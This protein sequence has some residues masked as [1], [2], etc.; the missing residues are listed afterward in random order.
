MHKLK[1]IS[2]LFI[3]LNLFCGL[4]AVER[5]PVQDSA[6]FQMLPGVQGDLSS[7]RNKNKVIRLIFV[8]HG[9]TFSNVEKSVAGRTTDTDLTEKGIKQAKMVAEQLKGVKFEKIFVSPTLRTQKTALYSSQ[10]D[11]HPFVEEPLLLE[12]HFGPY[13]GVSEE[14]WKPARIKE[15]SAIAALPTFE[16]KFAFKIDPG[17][18][19]FGEVQERIDLFIK[20][21]ANSQA[22]GNYLVVTHAAVTKALF[23]AKSA[24]HGYD[25]EYYSFSSDNCSVIVVEVASSG[26]YS[27]VA[28]QG[29]RF[30]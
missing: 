26:E 25:L 22:T 27:I 23:M 14:M 30:Y 5:T 7:I 20:D 24:E 16:E 6:M 17:M 15:A 3:S 19:S 21:I 8:R 2:V 29:L 1:L 18:E 28:V 9:E 4:E 12:R 11:P 13:E 10:Y